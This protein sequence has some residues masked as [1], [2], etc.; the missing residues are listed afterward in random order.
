VRNLVITK[1]GSHTVYDPVT[2]SHFHSIH[3][4]ITES[5][6][7]FIKHGFETVIKSGSVLRIFEMGFGTGLNAYLSLLTIQNRGLIV[8]YDSIET[9]PLELELISSLNYAELL[10]GK[11]E[12]I[13]FR[14]LHNC[15]WNKQIEINREFFLH[16]Y[17]ISWD[18]FRHFKPYDLIYFDAFDPVCQP[19]LWNEESCTKLFNMMAPNAVL[20]TYCAKGIVRRNLIA[21]GFIVEKL[22]GPPGKREMTRAFKPA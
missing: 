17:L 5:K 13:N 6:H 22:P 15:E 19:E 18:S 8:Y 21:A 2:H 3:G 11:K 7:V 9:K 16:K 4:A 1:D 10:S 12:D 14:H 20:C